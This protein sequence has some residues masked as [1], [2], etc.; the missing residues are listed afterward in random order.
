MLQALVAYAEFEKLSDYDAAFQTRFEKL[1]LTRR[2]RTRSVASILEQVLPP[3]VK[4]P[5]AE[6]M[7]ITL[8]FY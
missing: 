5:D 3:E 4:L 2:T 7:R 8:A 1:T 6:R